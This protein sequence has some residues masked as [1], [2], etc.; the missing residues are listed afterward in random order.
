MLY[1]LGIE[2]HGSTYNSFLTTK[3]QVRC[4]LLLHLKYNNA[5]HI[6]IFLYLQLLKTRNFTY[7]ELGDE[8]R[9]KQCKIY[10]G[11]KFKKWFY[12]LY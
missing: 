7:H 1:V 12:S 3:Q 9:D 11:H 2:R 6:H 5:S 4:H 10:V 8:D